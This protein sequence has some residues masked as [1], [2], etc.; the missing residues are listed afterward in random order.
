MPQGMIRIITDIKYSLILFFRNRQSVFFSLIFP[1]LFLVALGY[2]LGGQSG[3]MAGTANGVG[4]QAAASRAGYLDFLLPGI[5]SMC[6]MFSAINV[7]VGPMVKYR[8]T[9]T[10]RKIAT[11]PLTAFEL[12]ESRT[13]AGVF[14]VLL[15]VAVSL[16]MAWLAFGVVPDINPASVLIVIAGSVTF[17][18]LGMILAYL[19][20]DPESVN[21][22]AYTIIIPLLFI[23]GSL[24]PVDRLPWY[25]QFFSILSPLTY[26]N[27]GLRSSMFGDSFGDAITNLAISLFLCFVL[28]C[29]G[30]AILMG[31]EE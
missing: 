21:A 12:N 3:P 17:V 1:V 24:F 28:F 29:L 6:I 23:S 8:T 9:G 4:P 19:V 15:S 2:L 10:F 25:L 13:I 30:V 31:K 11:T 5:I 27:N 26:L 22:A 7:T 20:D 16:L 18:G 14:L